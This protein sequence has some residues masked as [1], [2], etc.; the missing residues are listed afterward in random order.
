MFITFLQSVS[1][2]EFS[3]LVYEMLGNNRILLLACVYPVE[4][5]KSYAGFDLGEEFEED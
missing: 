2:L 4:K 5:R 3:R 1:Y